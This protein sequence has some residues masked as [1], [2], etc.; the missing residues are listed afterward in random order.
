MSVK[1]K[2]PIMSSVLREEGKKVPGVGLIFVSCN[3][4]SQWIGY[5]G[6][7]NGEENIHFDWK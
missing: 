2:V 6:K 5:A 1:E 4:D 3:P 7:S